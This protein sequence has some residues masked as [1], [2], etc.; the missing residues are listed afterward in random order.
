MPFDDA[1]GALPASPL[2]TPLSLR[3]F[4]DG[5]E[6]P[7]GSLRG[8]DLEHLRLL[9]GALTTCYEGWLEGRPDPDWHALATRIRAFG[10]PPLRTALEALGEATLAASDVP[11]LLRRAF[12]DLRGGAFFALRLYGILLADEEPS[13]DLVQP[14]IFLARDQ[15]KL[16]RSL[17]PAMDP[18]G[19]RKDRE[20]RAHGMRELVDKWDGFQF[21]PVASGEGAQP[22]DVEVLARWRGDLAA[23]CLEAAA[24]DRVIYNLVNN[25]ARFTTDARVQLLVEAVTHATVRI[26][27]RNSLGSGDADWIASATGGEPDRLFL[28]GF[29]RGGTGLGLESSAVIVARAWGQVTAEEAVESGV[30]GARTADG[31]FVSWFFWPAFLVDGEGRPTP[32]VSS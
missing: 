3:W 7:T 8:R 9:Y 21:P 14:A 11:P 10:E 16:V 2:P 22:V 12:H 4:G 26:A 24:L 18:E 30:V 5:L 15:A 31:I 17:V 25:A 29:T 1:F 19:Y 6:I 20:E 13:E 23:R 27:V 28:G 32:G